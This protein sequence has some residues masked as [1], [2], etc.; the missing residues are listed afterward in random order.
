MS[1]WME[2]SLVVR[3]CLFGWKGLQWLENVC[4]DGRVFSG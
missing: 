4:L 2:A 3:K 1:I